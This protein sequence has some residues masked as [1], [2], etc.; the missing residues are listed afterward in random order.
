MELIIRFDYGHVVPWVRK[1]HGGVEA[2]AGP[3]GLILRTPIETQGK[4]LT[5]VAEFTVKKGERVP[6]VLTWFESH[7]E[8]PKP[9]TADHAL[10]DTEQF[11]T[12]WSQQCHPKT[13]WDDAVVRSLVVL[14][15]L[16]YAPTGG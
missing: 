7:Q 14:K 9:V 15:G 13:A 4:D 6:F 10:R 11:W 1:Q 5:T 16:T 8:P 3:D 12:R 2:I